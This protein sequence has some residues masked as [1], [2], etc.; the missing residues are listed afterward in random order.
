MSHP[1]PFLKVMMNFD[2]ASIYLQQLACFLCEKSLAVMER[3]PCCMYYVN[4]HPDI[5]NA[6][7]FIEGMNLSEI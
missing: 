2:S 6:S 4:C 3:R 5:D 7:V 1:A